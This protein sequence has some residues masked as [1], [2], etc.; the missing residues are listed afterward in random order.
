MTTLLTPESTTQRS[1]PVADGQRFVMWDVSWDVYES[2]RNALGDRPIRITYDGSNLELMSPSRWHEIVKSLLG[3]FVEAFTL[4][5]DI[6]IS[7]G[8]SMTFKRRD[9]LRGLEPDECY[10]IAN[11]IAVRG[12]RELDLKTAPP[13]DLA[14]EVDI[15]RS[16]LDRL[17]IYAK[18]RIPEVWRFDGEVL[19][20]LLLQPNG[21]YSTSPVSAAFPS[22]PVSE[23]T[24]FL[25]VDDSL[26]ETACVRRF[27]EW[28]REQGFG[29]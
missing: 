13:P 15:S 28:V 4:E 14:I 6:P 7:S 3:R 16:S 20:I 2:L 18:L 22:L 29:P 9:L 27:I 21:E 19:E 26:S 25:P 11:E 5:L 10:W 24:R 8:G 23:L 17:T 1:V 12:K